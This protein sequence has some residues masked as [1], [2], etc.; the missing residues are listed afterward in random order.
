L[1]K[2][3]ISLTQAGHVKPD[4]IDAAWTGGDGK[5]CEDR[6]GRPV[7]LTARFAGT[8]DDSFAKGLADPE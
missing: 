5:V 2:N 6:G 4:A 8:L 7:E 1:P 3:Q